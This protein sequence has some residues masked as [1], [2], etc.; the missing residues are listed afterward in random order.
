MKKSVNSMT[1]KEFGEQL[2]ELRARKGWVVTI[3][4]RGVWLVKVEDKET[5][6]V[7][8][9]T[10]TTSLDAIV[11]LLCNV[12][13]SKWHDLNLDKGRGEKPRVSSQRKKSSGRRWNCTAPPPKR[14]RA[15]AVTEGARRGR[16]RA[17]K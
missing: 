15:T 11:W 4:C 12:P 3:E 13:L 9:E 16:N 10:G 5:G 7:L 1:L 8:I 6:E 17:G 2:Q 14:A